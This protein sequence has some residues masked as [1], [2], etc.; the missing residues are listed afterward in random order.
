M[1]T[2]LYFIA[3]LLSLFVLCILLISNKKIDTLLV[4][5]GVLVCINNMGRY[6]IAISETQEMAVWATK[7]MYIGGI[8]CPVM[9]ILL[10]AQLCDL[11]MPK[12]LH[13]LMMT[14]ATV[15]LGFVL[16][17]GYS[18][19]YYS[20]IKLGL[21]GIQL[22]EENL[23]PGACSVSVIYDIV[24]KCIGILYYLCNQK[25]K[26]YFRTHCFHTQF[27]WVYIGSDISH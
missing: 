18:P 17:I 16:T 1:V 26:Q 27:R 15:V 8:Y 13:L 11:K 4:I 2:F 6:M 23:W 25:E 22:H 7:L 14:C 9:F 21:G 5:V 19:I 3:F 10:I 12:W 20:N 24:R